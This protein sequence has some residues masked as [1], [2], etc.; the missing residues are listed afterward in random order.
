[1]PKF[2]TAYALTQLLTINCGQ[3]LNNL[4]QLTPWRKKHP[5]SRA[6]SPKP[7]VFSA[8]SGFGTGGITNSGNS[9]LPQ[10]I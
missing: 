8:M 1:M 9:R 10:P 6:G 4:L 3:Q 7:A 5:Y 2:S